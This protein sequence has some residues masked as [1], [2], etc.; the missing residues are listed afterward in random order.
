MTLPDV[1]NADGTMTY[2]KYTLDGQNVTDGVI[3]G[4]NSKAMM[5]G[6]EE[7]ETED[8]EDTEDPEDVE[9]TE[10][11]DDLDDLEEEDN[12]ENKESRGAKEKSLHLYLWDGP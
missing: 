9:E 2:I 12:E 8:M 3:S 4:S 6:Y 7:E 1:W 10:V 11:T 5:A